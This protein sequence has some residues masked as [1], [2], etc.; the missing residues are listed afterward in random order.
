MASITST[1][2][3]GALEVMTHL[4]EQG[5]ERIGFIGG[6]E[7]LES[8]KR[9]L[10]GYKD[11]LAAAAIR[12]DES[13]VEIGDFTAETGAILAKR[14]LSLPERP[15]A[16]FAANDTTAMGVLEAAAE[17]NLSVPDDL[18]LVGFDNTPEAQLSN[19]PITTV[20][21]A[22]SEMG[23]MATIKL[24]QLIN[25]EAKPGEVLKVQTRLIERSSIKRIN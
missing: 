9:R 8:A 1:N 19:P 4:I 5:H 12:F 21:Q 2:R 13:L 7:G 6:R 10:V 22:V 20:D 18:S 3:E 11:G 14:L 25:Q 24:V 16:I 17:M 23:Y 15:T